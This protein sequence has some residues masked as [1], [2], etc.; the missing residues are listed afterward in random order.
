MLK[1]LVYRCLRNGFLPTLGSFLNGLAVNLAYGTYLV[2]AFF[3]V[4]EP[5]TLCSASHDT[6]IGN[7][8]TECDT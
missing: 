5:Y 2:I 8:Y 7:A 3:Q 1:L 6:E 4:D